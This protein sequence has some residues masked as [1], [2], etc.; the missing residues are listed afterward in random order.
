M[1]MSRSP[2]QPVA[3]SWTSPTLHANHDH[4]PHTAHA[5]H[6]PN[7]ATR[8]NG[9]EDDRGL[10]RARLLEMILAN[11]KLRKRSAPHA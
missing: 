8:T 2:S 7:P 10:L 11:E 5:P 3:S 6:T 4:A 1:D 9:P